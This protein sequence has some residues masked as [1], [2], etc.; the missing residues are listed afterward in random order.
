MPNMRAERRF[1]DGIQEQLKDLVYTTAVNTWYINEK[2]GKNTL[3][4]PGSQTAFWWSRCMQAIKPGDWI[5]G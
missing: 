1:N 4:W 5:I 2:T 3:I